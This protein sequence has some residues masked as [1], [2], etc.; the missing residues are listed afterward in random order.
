MSASDAFVH[1]R[2]FPKI[3][4]KLKRMID[5]G[6]GYLKLGQPANKLSGGEAQRLKLASY[7]ASPSKGERLFIM[8]ELSNGLHFADVVRIIDCLNEIVDSG[9]SVILIDHNPLV[10]KAADYIVDIGPGAGE[11]GGLIVAQGV[12]EEIAKRVDSATGR[13]LASILPGV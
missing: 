3:Q 9:N 1:F 12:P 5:V 2:S 13:V 11:Q 4:Y 8:D 6:L 7:L 10:M